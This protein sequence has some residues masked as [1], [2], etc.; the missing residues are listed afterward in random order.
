MAQSINPAWFSREERLLADFDSDAIRQLSRA[1]CI[2]ILVYF[3][4]FFLPESMRKEVVYRRKMTAWRAI[5]DDGDMYCLCWSTTKYTCL[6]CSIPICN[7]CS[8]FEEDEDYHGGSLLKA[9]P[10]RRFAFIFF[11]FFFLHCFPAKEKLLL[12]DCCRNP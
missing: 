2:I 12:A 8:I 6:K 9:S 4:C 5:L 1:K 11:F 3:S 7:N 10:L